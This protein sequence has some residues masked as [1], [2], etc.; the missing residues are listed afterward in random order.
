MRTYPILK[1]DSIVFAFEIEHTCVSRRSIAKLLG[2]AESV[3][4]VK[5]RGHFGS[6]DDVRLEFTYRG[7]AFIVLEPFGDSSRY[8]IGPEH[9]GDHP[10]DIG[11]LK[12]IFDDYQPLL[13]RMMRG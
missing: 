6:S 10:G 3:A 9:P 5:L 11:K 7:Q 8:W 2:S 4:G 13:L 12:K 1:N